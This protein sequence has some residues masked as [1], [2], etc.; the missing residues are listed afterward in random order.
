MSDIVTQP[1]KFLG[2]TVLSFNTSLGLGS[3]QES[4]LSVDLIED[5]EA[6]DV[7]LP[8]VNAIEVGAPVYFSTGID[9]EGFSFGGVLTNWSGSQGGSGRTF[10]VKVVDPRQLLENV[11]VVIDSYNGPPVKSTN[12]FNIYAQLEGGG[13]NT[14]GSSGSTERGTPYNSII[15][16]LKSTNPSICSPTGYNFQIN[17]DSFP[18]GAPDYYRISGP[19]VTILQLIQDIC[20]VLGLEFYVYMTL[21]I[22]PNGSPLGIIN[23]GTIDLKIPPTSFSNIIAQF[24]G[25]A[26]DL[27]YGEELRN[28]VTKSLMF[29]E[30]QHYLSPVFKFNFYFGEEWDGNDFIP[31]IPYAFEKCY[32][33]WIRKRIPELNVTLSR[34]FGGNG[35]YTISEQDIRA[36]MASFD[37]WYMRV[38]EPSIKGGLNA[39]IRANTP[40][41][42]AGPRQVIDAVRND[43]NIPE[44]RQHKALNDA[45]VGPTKQKTLD[46]QF[47][48]DLQKIHQF[49]QN[50]G[51][52]YYGKQWFTPLNES[53]C[54]YRGQNFQEKIFSSVPTNEGGWVDPGTAV[55]GLNDPDL[56]S[57][58]QTDDRISCFAVFAINDNDVPQQDKQD[59][60]G[61]DTYG[62]DTYGDDNYS[63][64][65]G[66]N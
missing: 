16:A 35:P 28:E 48:E 44:N 51:S 6:G 15:N 18:P 23:I 17:F 43:P 57:F 4:T 42:G 38:Y 53:I 47:T 26:T 1:I 25:L 45:M 33:F 56:G 46:E 37:A 20:G 65:G 21:G 58:R 40:R 2:A 3:A 52:T 36:A 66:G 49:V 55:L 61:Q 7:F 22:M 50:L 60:V 64:G 19:S 14:F 13:C 41:E 12:Y 62:E 54:Y 34:P 8:A 39:A 29:G 63:P 59:N 9:G 32:G 5:C 30:K 31:V 27:S 24:D 11:V 10:N